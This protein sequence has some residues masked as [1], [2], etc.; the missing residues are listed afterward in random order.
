MS[1]NGLCCD[2]LRG[3][4]FTFCIKSPSSNEDG[5]WG[6]RIPPVFKVAGTIAI[7]VFEYG[8]FFVFKESV[9]ASK[10]KIAKSIGV[11]RHL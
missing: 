7:K 3:L 6:W 5:V 1:S 8:Y 4:L 11:P 9:G 10:R 2:W